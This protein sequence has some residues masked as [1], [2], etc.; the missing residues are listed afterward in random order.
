MTLLC[1]LA[2]LAAGALALWLVALIDRVVQD[3]DGRAAAADSY[4][5]RPQDME[6]RDGDWRP[7]RGRAKHRQ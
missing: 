6:W 2:I 3:D 5:L 4:G 7:K 1:I